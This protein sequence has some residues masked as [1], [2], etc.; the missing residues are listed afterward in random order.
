MTKKTTDFLARNEG[1]IWLFTPITDAAH[2]W[3]A[4]HIPDDAQT[5]GESIVVEH[6]YIGRIVQGAAND[7]LRVKVLCG[8]YGA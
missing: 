8:I 6:R 1:S 7:G 2:A 3:V 4:E 5:W